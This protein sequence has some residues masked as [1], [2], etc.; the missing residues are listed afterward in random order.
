M[1]RDILT[2]LVADNG[3][4]Y[5]M[6]VLKKHKDNKLLQRVFKMAMDKATYTY[7][8]TLK[9][10]GNYESTEDQGLEW[11]L[12]S[13]MFL[14]DRTHTGNEAIE[15][16]N[17]LLSRLSADD[18]YV[19]ERIIDRDLKVGVGRS[20][21]NKVWKGLIV[22]P[23]Y[24]RCDIYTTDKTVW[25]EKKQKDVFK[26]GTCH[27]INFKNGAYLQLKADGTY[28]ETVV[29]NSKVSYNS[30]SGETY[31][32]PLHTERFSQVPD[33]K[34]IGE[35]TVVLD[36]ELLAL[37]IPEIRKEDPE[38]ADEII[39]D[40][41]KGNKILP[42]SIGNGL[43]NS[44][45]PPHKNIVF[46]LWDYITPEEYT[47]AINREVNTTS[48]EERFN[49]LNEIMV[50]HLGNGIEIIETHIVYSLKEAL[51][52][53]SIWM[54]MGLEGSILKD[55]KNNVFKDGI[56][57]YQLKLKLEIDIDVR[58]VAF[59]EGNKGSKHEKYFSGVEF[60]TDDG[61]IKGSV[62]VTSMSEA[63][64][65][66]MYERMDEL[67]GEVMTVQ[68]NDITIGRGHEHYALSHPRYIE[69]RTDKNETDTLER[70]FEQKESAMD[71]GEAL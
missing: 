7:G 71:L 1:I 31:D 70:A 65:D 28:R 45:N 39:A 2:E 44:S 17:L 48:Y 21:A 60:V 37:I 66:W 61:K 24:M 19:V 41:A 56:S 62:G 63:T 68:C 18:A 27:K 38:M 69:I 9:S 3:A 12:D 46:E 33:G 35:L 54:N 50:T 26:K 40:Y 11:A 5:K 29:E 36:E 6:D 64:R 8:I 59:P 23:A 4:N 53:T 42:R 49:K 15:Y 14:V 30:R 16:L 55:K 10:V 43:I 51:I 32:Y 67:I 52:Q 25:D 20:N 13:L 58:I 34:Y 22:K 57:A 47:R